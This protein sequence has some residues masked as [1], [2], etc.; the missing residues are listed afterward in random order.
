MPSPKPVRVTLGPAGS[1]KS[2]YAVALCRDGGWILV[3]SW[4]AAE[5]LRAGSEPRVYA[6]TFRGLAMRVAKVKGSAIV[7]PPLRS[8]LLREA[9]RR[10]IAPNSYFS[11]SAA[12]PGFV[13][14][15]GDLIREFKQALVSVEQFCRAASAAAGMVD[16]PRF[17]EKCHSIAAVWQEYAELLSRYGYLDAEDLL[18]Q[19]I[20]ATPGW[21]SRQRIPVVVV[22]G[23]TTFTRQ[24]LAFLAAIRTTG[25]SLSICLTFDPARPVLF[26][27]IARTLAELRQHLSPLEE[28]HLTDRGFHLQS[29]AL[30]HVERRV[31][32]EGE[33]DA[34][35]V[36]DESV[37]IY[38]APDPVMEAEMV[39]RAICHLQ[40]EG[41]PL[42]RIGVV[43]R[44]LS[45]SL[46]L[47]KSTF[48]RY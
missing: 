23:F 37:C 7:S 48:A 34:A 18:S 45:G 9:V 36:C 2:R 33:E 42:A 1:G 38:S 13:P 14:A 29:E 47:L 3:P 6:S 39:A 43:H 11:A 41:K 16:D 10:A 32:L 15:V 28:E 19:A 17:V 8:F 27:R 26:A 12:R 35:P 46:P 24:Q 44:A 21:Y 31:F 30:R 5:S 20:E 40:R 22:D 25:A 4:A